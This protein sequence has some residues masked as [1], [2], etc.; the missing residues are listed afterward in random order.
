[1]GQRTL[2]FVEGE[3]ISV[4][5]GP[6]PVDPDVTDVEIA[7]TIGGLLDAKGDL[8]AGSD[9]D[10]AA[11]L[12][13]GA[14]GQILT[15]DSSSDTG[16]AWADASGGGGGSPTGAAGGVLSGTY[17]NPGFAADM[18]TQ[19]E[20]NTVAATI[21]TGAPF[22]QLGLFD[23]RRPVRRLRERCRRPPAG[24]VEQ[25]GTHSRLDANVGGEVGGPVRR[26]VGRPHR[27]HRTVTGRRRRSLVRFRRPRLGAET[28]G[29]ARTRG[30]ERR[31]CRRQRRRR[32]RPV[33]R[34][35]EQPGVDSRLGADA[36]GEMGGP[37]DRRRRCGHPHLDNHPGERRHLRPLQPHG[38]LQRPVL[39]RDRPRQLRSA[40]TENL[41]WRF[42]NDSGA[43]YVS[44]RI[45]AAATT[46]SSN[47]G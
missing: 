12:P 18:A 37:R 26:H 33:A 44:T 47:E 35:V 1:M 23:A 46:V 32:V 3:G 40:N 13:V 36:R 39:H 9:L 43:N 15:A 6:S 14:D 8:V 31:P 38:R 29:S 45:I 22:V 7:N 17:P 34:R 30:R 11:R 21:P 28:R 24:R 2:N 42:N 19:A 41:L 4:Q 20:L 25:P 5:T 27:R 16:L 10:V